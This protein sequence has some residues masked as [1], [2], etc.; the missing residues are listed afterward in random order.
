[1][2]QNSESGDSLDNSAIYKKTLGFS[3]RRALWDLLVLLVLGGACTAGFF[4]AEKTTDKGLV[5]LG[6][7]AVIGII[8]MVIILRFV[9][10][11]L[12]AGQI[13]MMT[14]GIV[15]GELPDDVIA[16]GKKAVKERF[17]TVAVFYA[18]TGV[19]KGIFNQLGRVITRVGES[20]GGD[21]GSTVGSAISTAIQVVVS[22]LCDCCLGWV[23]YRKEVKSARATCE[24]AVLFFRHGK[25]L[26][27]NL[28]R[29]FGIGL[30]S[31]IA[32]G[33]VFGGIAWLILSRF[34]ATFENLAEEISEAAARGSSKIPDF[35]TN[36]DTLVI[37]AAVLIG[38]IIWSIIHSVFIRPFVLT[39]VL[40]NYINSG[41]DDIP[42]E[43]AFAV[44][45]GKSAKFKKLHAETA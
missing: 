28:G 34:P 21:A 2:N 43:A 40:R 14:R 23:F 11:Y 37:A 20:V 4:I 7:G 42:D 18:A 31:L 32:I 45:D 19:I 41:I 17:T 9:S 38:V 15:E 44:L 29:I 36:P 8:I 25:T 1:M 13:A 33:G 5:G 24:G 26:A 6:I 35:L 39:G 30:L 10:Y 27:K 22:Y 12:K 16:E 3:L